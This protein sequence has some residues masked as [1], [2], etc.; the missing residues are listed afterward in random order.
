M[1]KST[2]NTKEQYLSFRDAWKK[3]ANS[4]KAKKTLKTG[5]YGTYRTDGWL[6]A[7]HHILFNILCGRRADRGFTPVTNSN[8]LKSG[9][10]LNHGFY[11]AMSTLVRLQK[12]AKLIVS[13]NTPS[14]WDSDR[15]VDFLAPFDHTVT[16][17]LFAK[18]ELPKVEAL[19]SS[20]GKSKKVAT[21][22]IEGEFKPTDFSQVYD[23][24]AEVA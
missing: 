6:H 8:K 11:F 1:T 13:G 15:L 2:F 3:A 5:D 23:A 19:Y 22:I 10:Y 4:E 9:T 24:I 14:S 20:Y 17:D 7:Q 16:V 21:R 12:T 18:L